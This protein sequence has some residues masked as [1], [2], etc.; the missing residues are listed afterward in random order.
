[1]AHIV[2]ITGRLEAA[3]PQLRLSEDE[4]YTINDDKNVILKMQSATDKLSD[5]ESIKS[6]GI[7]LESLLGKEQ[8]KE[9]EKN[10]PG[11]TTSLSRMV[12]LSIGCMA[13]IQGISYEDAEARFRKD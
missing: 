2:D 9:I 10:H 4:V 11:A 6:M 13:A 8:I 1:M 12:V 7:L 5:E 3:V